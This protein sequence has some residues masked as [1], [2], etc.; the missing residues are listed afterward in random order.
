MD[1]QP[2][3]SIKANG[4]EVS[5]TLKNRLAELSVTT[6]TGLASDTCYVRFDN[7]AD[8]PIALP[9]PTDQLEIAMGYKEGTKD[10]SAP[11]TKLGIF[12]VGAYELTGPNRSLTFYGNKVLWDQDF[13]ALKIRSWPEQGKDEPLMLDK[14]I[15]DIAG[16][17]GLQAKIGDAFQGREIPH[18]EQTESDMQLLSKLAVQFDAIMKIA[19]DKLIFMAKG[20]GKSLT[21]KALPSV[22]VSK[23]QLV[24]WQLNANHNKLVKGVQAYFYDKALAQKTLVSVGGGSPNT[25]LS[26][27]YPNETEAQTAATAMLQRLNRAHTSVQLCVVG[28]PNLLAGGVITIEEVDDNLNGDWFVCEVKHVINH[29]GFKSYLVCEALG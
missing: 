7:L 1:L 24:S 29:A 16:E 13:K 6:R 9:A 20:T 21:G 26:Y 15:Q 27:V 17:Y 11:S 19:D 10:Q 8:A 2:H 22:T 4:N 12:E 14:L 3:Y 28:D 25:T 23:K 18:I 5:K